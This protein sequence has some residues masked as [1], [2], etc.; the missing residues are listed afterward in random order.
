VLRRRTC[1]GEHEVQRSHCGGHVALPDRP[2][3]LLGQLLAVQLAGNQVRQHL[4][5][6]EPH[7][8]R[9][10]WG[11]L[12]SEQRNAD[13]Q[14]MPRASLLMVLISASSQS[15]AS[16][17]PQKRKRMAAASIRQG[18][19]AGAMHAFAVHACRPAAQ[20]GRANATQPRR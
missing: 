18:G 9:R 6:D 12:R 4:G 11:D 7:A 19:V 17:S 10:L 3:R 5:H 8:H 14:V 13:A 2:L 16:S 1:V 15:G 20:A